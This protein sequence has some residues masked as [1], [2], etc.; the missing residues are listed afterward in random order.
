MG[1]LSLNL[2]VRN[3]QRNYRPQ[4]FIARPPTLH[5][6][7]HPPVDSPL[8]QPPETPA[9]AP[10][11]CPAS[12]HW[13][14][15]EVRIVL[16]YFILA[17]SWIIGSDLW[18]NETTP[19]PE[20]S[21]TIQILKGLNFVITTA[22]LLFFVLRHAYTGWRLAEERRIDNIDHARER[23]RSLSSH[24]Q[25]LRENDRAEISREIH[26]ELGQLLTGIQMQLRLIEDRLSDREDRTLNPLIDK[27]VETSELVDTTITSVQRISAG[28]RPSSLDNLGLA[29]AV[30][31]EAEL[32]S[33]RSGIRCEVIFEEIPDHLPAEVTTPAFRIF[34]EALTN[35]A[36]HAEASFIK[37][38]L[39][40]HENML[41]LVVR[42]DGRG[43][44][45]ASVEDPKSL[46][47]MGMFERAADIGGRVV[48]SGRPEKGT[49]VT[50]TIPLPPAGSRGEVPAPATLS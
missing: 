24:V 30:Q 38:E 41:T 36:R 5:P 7:E 22:V 8:S 37:A 28:L 11:E 27:I 49:C 10:A 19:D 43:I 46:G 2:G 44:D 42:D 33:E 4:R 6:I 29:T 32:F 18:L 34:Q 1:V 50:L 12:Q 21:L 15:P 16:V 39:S 48:I 40:I 45:L 17:S 14:L 25:T 20:E 31:G 47:L 3:H 35:V 9:A 13:W 26:D 23:F